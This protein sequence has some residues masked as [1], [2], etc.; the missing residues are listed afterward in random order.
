MRIRGQQHYWNSI[1]SVANDVD[2]SYNV[3]ELQTAIALQVN[4]SVG[5]AAEFRP[6]RHP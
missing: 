5:P 6:E 2:D 1:P 4:N 3:P